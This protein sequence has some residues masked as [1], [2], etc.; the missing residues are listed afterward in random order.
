MN[1]RI[2]VL[3]CGFLAI[4][5]TS[6][7]TPAPR[8]HSAKSS[9]N[10]ASS[11]NQVSSKQETS[12]STHVHTFD[13]K[14]D[15]DNY[16]HWHSATCGHNAK[17]DIENHQF[18]IEE[19]P[20]TYDSD[21][22]KIYTCT[23]CGYTREEKLDQLEHRYDS[24]W[25][26]DETKHWKKCLDEGYENLNIENADHIFSEEVT[27]PS[28]FS[29]GYTTH[30]CT[31]CGYSYVDNRIS[32]FEHNNVDYLPENNHVKKYK[33]VFDGAMPCIGKANVLVFYVD[34]DGGSQTRWEL[35][36]DQLNDYFFSEEGKTNYNVAYSSRDSIRSFYYRS[37]YGR[38]DITGNVYEYKT[39]G[40]YN[41]YPYLSSVVNEIVSNFYSTIEWSDYDANN[42]GYIDGLFIIPKTD[43]QNGYG[44]TYISTFYGDI[45][46]ANGYRF[47]NV[48]YFADNFFNTVC[49]ETCHMFGI[50]DMYDNVRLNPNGMGV[51]SIMDS[52]IGDGDIPSPAKFILGWLNDVKFVDVG[53]A[54]SFSLKSFSYEGSCLIVKP[55]GDN[56]KNWF[57]VDYHTDEGS[58]YS[59]VEVDSFKNKG[60]RIMRTQMNID[61]DFNVIGY[62]EFVGMGPSPYLYLAAVRP[63]INLNESDFYL[64][65]NEEITPYTNPS[66]A[67]SDTIVS[68][69]SNA[70]LEN[71]L[72]SGISI[73]VNEEKSLSALVEITYDETPNVS[74]E[75]DFDAHIIGE[76]SGELLNSPDSLFIFAITCDVELAIDSN[77]YLFNEEDDTRI[78]LDYRY[79]EL[80]KKIEFYISESQMRLINMDRSY[81]ANINGIRTYYGGSLDTSHVVYI[82]PDVLKTILSKKQCGEITFNGEPLDSEINCHNKEDGTLVVVYYGRTENFNKVARVIEYSP[83]NNEALN[84]YELEMPQGTTVRNT[85]TMVSWLGKNDSLFVLYILD[86][87]SYVLAKYINGG[88]VASNNI[89]S[90]Y[91]YL[92]NSGDSAWFAG[93]DYYRYKIDYESD[94]AIKRVFRGNHYFARKV[95]VDGDN[96][97]DVCNDSLY[98]VSADGR[99][100][101]DYVFKDSAGEFH[102]MYTSA[103]TRNGKLF[104]V[105]ITLQ[106]ELVG[107]VFDSQYRLIQYRT[108]LTRN[109]SMTYSVKI[110]ILLYNDSL[111]VV[112]DSHNRVISFAHTTVIII[113]EYLRSS[114]YFI[115]YESSFREGYCTF[116]IGDQL[117]MIRDMVGTLYKLDERP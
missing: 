24:S 52:S 71:F 81:I 53:N 106:E 86:D 39:T 82:N 114:K 46:P 41:D 61:D 95:I 107:F 79:D 62:Q 31:V 115:A 101:Q 23:V 14:W 110:N 58:D 27:D 42:D 105:G 89:D 84:S 49:H 35:T 73:K 25:S 50:P 65:E 44:R 66:S 59:G 9:V 57:F 75:V 12:S 26:F 113:D 48:A 103:I 28:F 36:K 85:Q 38:L 18:E 116:N 21:G 70:H 117:Y 88:L 34:F 8:V 108:I 51:G 60:V 20:A 112:F 83:A 4:G 94:L 33:N 93:N 91:N 99:V 54:D 3:L 13:D 80:C 92:N 111:A 109:S 29:D 5:I 64:H 37:S 6:C 22:I 98:V 15:Y 77:A 72:Y 40:A 55:N 78:A 68:D 47:S 74:S 97:I 1:K 104:I 87:Y 19:I 16:R 69:D 17:K 67:Y 63:D 10:D 102:F 11:I 43:W 30:T 76:N 96:Y 56:H 32:K 2:I 90:K 45:N 7:T 100:L